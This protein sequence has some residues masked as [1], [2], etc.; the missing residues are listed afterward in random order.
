MVI[1]YSRGTRTVIVVPCPGD[2]SSFLSLLE[3]QYREGLDDNAREYID[4]AV[5]GAERMKF[6][7]KGLLSY[8]RITTRGEP[9][10]LISSQEAMSAA[11]NNLH[12]MIFASGAKITSGDLPEVRGDLN[13]IS[14]LFK[15]LISNALKYKEQEIPWVEIGVGR[16][17]KYWQFYLRDNG[18][19]VDPANQERIFTIFQREHYRSEYSGAGVGL[20]ICKRIVERHG[21]KIWVDPTPGPGSTFY[22]PLLAA[23]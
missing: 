23:E 16:R 20:S 2:E 15:N 1:T 19:G 8:F 22:F 18:F 13:Q 5:V 10:E 12:L 7:V 6:M 14:Q 4:F 11:R 3:C 21:G 9:M 17:D